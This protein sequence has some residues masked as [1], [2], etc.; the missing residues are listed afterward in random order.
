[1]HLLF[2][3]TA[4]KGEIFDLVTKN[5]DVLD[6]FLRDNQAVRGL[7]GKYKFEGRSAGRPFF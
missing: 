3:W 1:M 4:A 7:S 2:C 6:E 5:I